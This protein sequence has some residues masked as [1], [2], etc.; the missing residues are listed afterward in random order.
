MC[1]EDF[2]NMKEK[3]VDHD[4]SAKNIQQAASVCLEAYAD[5][6]YG[7]VPYVVK[8]LINLMEFQ[9]TADPQHYEKIP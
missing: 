9:L 1:A 6:I 5:N 2:C 7:T 8:S 3:I 4:N